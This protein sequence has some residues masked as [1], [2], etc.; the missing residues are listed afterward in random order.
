MKILVVSN[1]YQSEKR[2]GNPIINR[3]IAAT[4]KDK[5]VDSVSFSPFSNRLRCFPII[6][7]S[8]KDVDIVHIH[9]GGVYALLIW[10]SLIGVHV[11]KILT[12]HGTD[13]HGKEALTT[14][15]PLA[16]L[17]IRLNQLSSFISFFLFDRIG[18]VSD[19]LI[20]FVPKFVYKANK[21]KVFI[22][23]LGVDYDLFRI[24]T[25]TEALEKLGLDDAHYVLFSDKTNT[26][27][28]RRDLAETIVKELGKYELLI[29]SGVSP[30]LVPYYINASDFTLLT[31]DEEGSPNIVRES[32][33]MNK[34][35]FSVDVGDVRSQIEGLSNSMI[36][37]RDPQTAAIQ[38]ERSL[39][40]AYTDN[41]RVKYKDRIDFSQIISDVV[42]IYDNLIL[43]K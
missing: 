10:I 23:P 12:F 18:V 20:S 38:I 29:M 25:R 37:S 35:V 30:E 13:I 6:R 19:T 24:F 2:Q 36:I 14:K 32:L 11:P 34:R 15:S 22:Q 33:A 26:P 21:R 27:L 42:D 41:S 9:F 39:K 31:S 1:E 16:K 40:I 28:K 17:R 3:I 43:V 7:R 5:R 8:A 4:A